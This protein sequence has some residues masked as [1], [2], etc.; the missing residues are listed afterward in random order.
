MV[1]GLESARGEYSIYLGFTGDLNSDL[2]KYVSKVGGLDW[3]KV[4]AR[5]DILGFGPAMPSTDNL[6]ESAKSGISQAKD[7]KNVPNF[8]QN[9]EKHWKSLKEHEYSPYNVAKES[10]AQISEK[11]GTAFNNPHYS[12][13]IRRACKFGLESIL[14]AKAHDACVHFLLDDMDMWRIVFKQTQNKSGQPA[15]PYTTSELR[16]AFRNRDKLKGHILYYRDHKTVPPPWEDQV[17]TETFIF[18]KK[19]LTLSYQDM[20]TNYYF[21]ANGTRYSRMLANALQKVEAND[22]GLFEEELWRKETRIKIEKAENTKNYQEM[23][24]IAKEA[25]SRIEPD[26]KLW[27]V[28]YG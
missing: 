11:E 25:L 21:A 8:K 22:A 7:V 10:G 16:H 23:D 13:A 17:S 15:I 1:Y 24:R 2:K 19:S 4:D 18:D 26:E 3:L 27:S 12:L 20:W 5:N 28:L 6:E 9:V 14:Q